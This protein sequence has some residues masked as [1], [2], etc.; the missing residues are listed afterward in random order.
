MLGP[1]AFTLLLVAGASVVGFPLAL[2]L[3]MF[4]LLPLGAFDGP[5]QSPVLAVLIWAY[6]SA[7]IGAS[8]PL[9]AGSVLARWA[10]IDSRSVRLWSIPIG[11]STLAAALVSVGI[12][13]VCMELA[14]TR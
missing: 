9:W 8:A 7:A 10:E 13:L 14:L 5:K 4:E 12:A 6:G 3:S 2:F 11:I 1:V